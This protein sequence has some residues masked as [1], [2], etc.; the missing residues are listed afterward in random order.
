MGLAGA[1]V[2]QKDCVLLG[3]DVGALSQLQDCLVVQ[4][5]D[6]GQ[7]KLIECLENWG[8]CLDDALA[9]ELAS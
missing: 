6:V 4:G 2:G 8:A 7:W 5:R 3:R 9:F 1:S